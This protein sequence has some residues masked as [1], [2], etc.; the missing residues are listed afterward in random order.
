MKKTILFLLVMATV[1]MAASYPF[2][3]DGFFF[4]V[5]VGFGG[6]GMSLT[7]SIYEDGFTI[8]MEGDA[9]GGVYEMDYKIGGRIL[10]YTILHAT[11]VRIGALGDL[12]TELSSRGRSVYVE[13]GESMLLV[14]LG[15]TCYIRPY[16]FFVSGSVG[17]SKFGLTEAG[18]DEILGSTEF[19]FGFQLAAGKEWWVSENW[20][21]GASIAL[22]YGS[23]EESEED[24]EMSALAITVMLSATFN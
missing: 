21:M 2:T 8:D 3:H 17:I 5:S 12:E 10:P 19:G 15:T 22:N 24:A 16:N 20:G 4:N 7:G 23:V 6:Q 11:V 18:D 13:N 14:G 1:A 9:D